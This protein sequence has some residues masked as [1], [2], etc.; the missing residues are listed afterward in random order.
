MM[1]F[2]AGSPLEMSEDLGLDTAQCLKVFQTQTLNPSL[3]ECALNTN[4]TSNADT[5]ALNPVS[6]KF[7]PT[8]TS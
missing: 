4:T 8:K 6:Y 5:N 3:P 7:P 2:D 1:R